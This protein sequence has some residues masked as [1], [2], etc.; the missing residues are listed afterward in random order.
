MAITKFQP[1][2]W[3]GAILDN[4]RNELVYAGPSIANHDYEGDI[5]S[6]GD[7]VHIVSFADPATRTYTK[8]GPI[9]WDVLTDA[10]LLLAIDQS[11]YFAF[12]VDDIDKRQSLPGFIAKAS[13]GAAYNLVADVDGFVSSTL[14]TS[15]NGSANDIGPVSVTA[16]TV[17]TQAYKLVILPLR[18]KLN[19]AKVPASGRWMV[20]PPELYAY[21]LQDSRFIANPAAGSMSDGPADLRAGFVG[22]IAGFDVFES[23]TVPV[24]GSA[25]HVIAGHRMA[26]TFADQISE[27]EAIRLQTEGFLD[28]IRGLHL[29]GAK[30][31]QPTALAL[32]TVTLT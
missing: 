11:K 8:G 31:V 9:T 12:T 13:A 23:N 10:E 19:R 22:R 17:A 25:Y 26:L 28:G 1:E 20:V 27:V 18:T 7:T 6:A 2:I 16:D 30:V 32:A 14:L 15:V 5:S 24:S 4:L 3:S 29:Y 21:L